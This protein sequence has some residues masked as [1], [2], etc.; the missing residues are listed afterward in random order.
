MGLLPDA[1]KWGETLRSGAK[2]MRAVWPYLLILASGATFAVALE[3]LDKPTFL[4]ESFGVV[5]GF[6][7]TDHVGF[8]VFLGAACIVI[9]AAGIGGAAD[10]KTEKHQRERDELVAQRVKEAI[11][12][13]DMA[14]AVQRGRDEER[15]R[16]TGRIAALEKDRDGWKTECERQQRTNL[17]EGVHRGT[18]VIKTLTATFDRMRGLIP[19]AYIMACSADFTGLVPGAEVSPASL[20]VTARG[21]SPVIATL[22]TSDLEPTNGEK[23]YSSEVSPAT[24]YHCLTSPGGGSTNTWPPAEGTLCD[25]EV[26]LPRAEALR[27]HRKSGVL[28][29]FELSGGD[30]FRRFLIPV[31]D[32]TRPPKKIDGR[33]ATLEEV[34]RARGIGPAGA[35]EAEISA[36]VAKLIEGQERLIRED[37]NWL[38]EQIDGRPELMRW[39]RLDAV[40]VWQAV[41]LSLDWDPDKLPGAKEGKADLRSMRSG[42]AGS[43]ADD[44]NKNTFAERLEQAVSHLDRRLKA[45]PR[46]GDGPRRTRLVG[47]MIFAAW[48]IDVMGWRVPF[49]FQVLAGKQKVKFPPG[50]GSGPSA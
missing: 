18:A 32:V 35:S 21:G 2:E 11:D 47:L 40:E 29:D 37:P 33:S 42:Y 38:R 13:V 20:L 3:L 34:K 31:V 27:A 7:T 48:A 30:Q 10:K 12:G 26:R 23:T 28:L 45:E 44:P 19:D 43:G 6:T 1:G 14:P 41:A 39:L 8:W 46:E 50:L 15:E 16:S 24:L 4:H 5:K 36:E 49:F 9:A 17:G 22:E 25:V